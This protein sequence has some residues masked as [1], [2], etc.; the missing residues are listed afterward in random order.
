MEGL[1]ARG[2]VS[3]ICWGDETGD[4]GTP[5]LQGYVEFPKKITLTGC[6]RVMGDRAHLET[7]QGTQSQAIA[8]CQ[9]DGKWVQFGERIAQGAREDLK[10]VCDRLASGTR[11][12]TIALEDPSLYCRYRNGLRDLAHFAAPKPIREPPIVVWIGG[13]PGTGKSKWAWSL[14]PE[15]T[16]TYPGSGWFDGYD[17]EDVA[18]FDDFQDDIGSGPGV[19]YGAI[20]RIT[21]R[22]PIRVPIKGGFVPWEPTRIVFTGNRP[23]SELYRSAPG[24][25]RS[26]ILRRFRGE[27]WVDNL[28]ELD[29]LGIN[30]F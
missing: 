8:Y 4:E 12:R 3:Y 26:A 16:W 23:L 5:H 11:L 28:G 24:T 13:P 21:D 30:D 25:D 6:K 29:G 19:T 22:Y 20:L 15:S 17:G 1:A 2:L 10:R 27:R 9:K 14:N 18:I 7:R